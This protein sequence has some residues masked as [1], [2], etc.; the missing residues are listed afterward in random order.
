MGDQS[1][2]G[3]WVEFAARLA[4]GTFTEGAGITRRQRMIQKRI[5]FALQARPRRVD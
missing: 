4:E 3:G 2:Q 5:E 1:T